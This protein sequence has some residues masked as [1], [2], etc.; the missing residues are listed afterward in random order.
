M[1]EYGLMVGMQ[2][3]TAWGIRTTGKEDWW[4]DADHSSYQ[5]RVGRW[6]SLVQEGELHEGHIHHC[7]LCIYHSFRCTYHR[8]RSKYQLIP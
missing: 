4:C 8:Y 5:G 1:F 7:T 3:R 2:E 6:I